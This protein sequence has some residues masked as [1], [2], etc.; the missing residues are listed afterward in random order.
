M[1]NLVF[2]ATLGGQVNLV[3]PNTASTFNLNVPAVSAT[4]ATTS[5]NTFTS[6][7][8][9]S[10]GNL[11]F[12]STTQK[13]TGDFSNATITNRL[14]FQTSTSNSSTGIYALP[15]GTSTAASWQATNNADPT[16]ASKILIATNGSTDVQLVSGING[17]GT[18][19]PLTF[20]T[21][22]SERMRLDTSGNLGLGVT[23]SAWN[24]AWKGIQL[25]PTAAFTNRS[26]QNL[27]LSNNWY[28]DSGGTDRYIAT[29][30]ASFYSQT[31]GAHNWYTAASGTAGNAIS[32]TQAMT[33]DGSGNFIVGGTTANG[34]AR[35]VA[36]ASS[37]CVLNLETSTNNYASA[38][39]LNALNDNGAIYNYI[40]S[41]SPTTE[42]WKVSGSGASST[43][44][45]S[46]GGSE[47]ARI[48]SSGNLLVGCTAQGGTQN[49]PLQL[50]KGSGVQWQVGPNGSNS[51]FVVM[52][53]A[54]V[55]VYIPSGN[56]SW[57]GTSDER[58]KDIIEPIT[59]AA[60]KVSTLRAVIGKYKTDDDG[61]RRS[62]LIAQ[63]VQAVLPEAVDAT[64]PD[65]LGVAYTD[66]IPLLVAA[67]KEL[68]AKVDAQAVEIAA[69]KG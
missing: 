23:P 47:R 9:I 12:S 54:D 66:V 44:V 55:G 8:T 17:T 58:L 29:G 40:R 26:N 1:G 20:Y 48:D 19:L 56:T 10:S 6:T 46:T 57:T 7:Q 5:A 33:L 43:M 37:D 62:F 2:Q 61:V 13:V 21:N 25:T 63:D 15:N 18:Y 14:A 22:G 67:I 68:N 4:L 51:A 28:I 45:L 34:R 50:K 35:F 42:H 65:K 31:S 64:N 38:I 16:N 3:G 49:A 36:A 59:E 27:Y 69:L 32:F 53:T 41:T 39:V 30:Y 24:S 11:T 52:N 60:S